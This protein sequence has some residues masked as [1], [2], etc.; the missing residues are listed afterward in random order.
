[1]QK[2]NYKMKTTILSAIL[3]LLSVSI[4][5]QGQFKIRNDAF[6][7]IGYNSYKTLTFGSSTGTPN[8]GNFALEYCSNCTS[9]GS[10]G[11]NIWKPWPTAGAANFLLYIRD[12]GNVGLGN[13]GDATA[14]LNVSG[15]IKATSFIT[16]SDERFKVNFSPLKTALETISTINVY[17][18]K[19]NNYEKPETDSNSVN[20]DKAHSS[21]T[22]DDKDHIGFK[23][24]EIEKIYPELVSKDENGYLS[25]NYVEFVP[26]LI[27]ALQEQNKKI[28]KLEELIENLKK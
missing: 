14:R 19:Y 23:A 20:V 24:Q 25:V 21:Y 15:S 1:M 3:S 2:Q 22:F 17:K 13:I 28:E 10:G 16:V 27:K 4:F 11:F 12:N 8:N 18:Y 6:V 7:Q 26:I 9:T 5:A